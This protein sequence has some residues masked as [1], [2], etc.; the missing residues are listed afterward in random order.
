[1]LERGELLTLEEF[2]E[3][4]TKWKNEKYHTRKHGGLKEAGEKWL[5]PIEMFENGPRYEKAAPP[6][7]YAAMLLMKADK[8]R[9]YNFGIKKFGTTYTCLLYT[10]RGRRR[11]RRS[12]FMPWTAQEGPRTAAGPWGVGEGPGAGKPLQIRP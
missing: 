2:F 8:A 7:E 1:M 5:T 11:G 4:W 10:S 6:R 9:V 12:F 3:V